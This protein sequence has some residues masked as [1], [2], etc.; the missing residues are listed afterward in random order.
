MNILA[1]RGGEEREG[2]EREEGAE[3]ANLR[4]KASHVPKVSRASILG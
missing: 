3:L 2:R 1:G 4:F